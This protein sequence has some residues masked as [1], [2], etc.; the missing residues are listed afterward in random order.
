MPETLDL[1]RPSHLL[2]KLAHEAALFAADPNNSYAAM[3]AVRD[4]YHLRA[5]VWQDRLQPA[6]ALQTL[7]MGGAGDEERWNGWL[8]EQFP[9][10][11]AIVGLYDRSKPL[12]RGSRVS[13]FYQR[14]AG[15]SA[16]LSHNFRLYDPGYYVEV[17]A[18]DRLP[19]NRLVS[20]VHYFWK[21]LFYRHPELH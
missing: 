14:S 13:S 2:A 21:N 12:M 9:G 11:A 17:D 1:T 15:G 5:W 3:N 7:V 20:D 10:Y 6:P 18:G 4:A 16:A 8:Q 19:I